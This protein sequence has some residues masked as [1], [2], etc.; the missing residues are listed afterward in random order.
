MFCLFWGYL[1]SYSVARIKLYVLVCTGLVSAVL[2]RMWKEAA[3]AYFK[4][5]T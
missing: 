4:V 3:I 2:E 1:M 5:V